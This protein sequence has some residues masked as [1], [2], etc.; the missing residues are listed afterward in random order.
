MSRHMVD[1]KFF[2]FVGQFNFHLM[3]GYENLFNFM[4]SYHLV[5][6]VSLEMFYPQLL[7][8]VKANLYMAH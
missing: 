6:T 5:D 4:L 2:E 3:I 1:L 8:I 7:S